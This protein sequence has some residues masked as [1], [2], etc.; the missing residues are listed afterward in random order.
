MSQVSGPETWVVMRWGPGWHQRRAGH[1][2]DGGCAAVLVLRAR[3][4]WPLLPSLECFKEERDEVARLAGAARARPRGVV[5]QFVHHVGPPGKLED[6]VAGDA[7]QLLPG[8]PDLLA[9]LGDAPARVDLRD[10]RPVASGWARWDGRTPGAARAGERAGGGRARAGGAWQWRNGTGG[11]TMAGGATGWE[12][13]S[14]RGSSAVASFTRSAST[15]MGS[16]PSGAAAPP[17]EMGTLGASSTDPTAGRRARRVRLRTL[18]CT[19][20]RPKRPGGGP[21]TGIASAHGPR[22]LP[23][24]PCPCGPPERG[25]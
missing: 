16:A 2:V 22:P 3:R 5:L 6:L 13:V 19:W 21:R 15:S 9:R 18:T 4:W 17:V 20:E 1:L 14:S 8:G 24:L 7:E 23:G 25:A 10:A 12:P 11:R